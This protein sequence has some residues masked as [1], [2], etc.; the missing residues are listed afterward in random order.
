MQIPYLKNSSEKRNFNKKKF[1]NLSKLPK[2]E[3]ALKFLFFSYCHVW[4]YILMDDRQ[5]SNITNFI[6]KHTHTHTHTEELWTGKSQMQK[7]LQNTPQKCQ[8]F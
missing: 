5:L 8:L 2:H 1:P 6:L 4:L 7:A 3:K